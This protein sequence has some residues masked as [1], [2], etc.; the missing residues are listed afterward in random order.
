MGL[1][2]GTKDGAILGL[3]VVI[4]WYLI[5]RPPLTIFGQQDYYPDLD[6]EQTN[7]DNFDPNKKIGFGST[8]KEVKAVIKL[9]N[10]YCHDLQYDFNTDTF[11]GVE[12]CPPYPT[13]SGGYLLQNNIIPESTYFDDKASTVLFNRFQVNNISYK[14]LVNALKGLDEDG[15]PLLDNDGKPR[16]S[17]WNN[18]LKDC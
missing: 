3:G 13:G 9:M 17:N 6:G 7:P 2:N 15:N 14:Q 18:Y 1:V 8:G 4:L 11:L 16:K 5:K 10:K 12:C